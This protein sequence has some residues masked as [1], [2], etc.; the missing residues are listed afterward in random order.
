MET[1]S[2]I[3]ELL[4]Q[5]AHAYYILDNPIMS[6]SE[7]DKLY[8]QLVDIETNDPSLITPDS[9]TQRVGAALDGE[10]EEIKHYHPMLSLDNV[11]NEKDIKKF[12]KR[13][14]NE[15]GDKPQ[16]LCEMK[17][18]GAA[19]SLVYQD[20]VL[21]HGA[22]RGDGETGEDITHNVRT[23]NT[24]PLR[25]QLAVPGRVEVRGEVIMPHDGF[26]AYNAKAKEN[27]G[28][29]FANPRNAAAGSL[30]QKDPSKTAGRPLVFIPY[31]LLIE[32]K[33]HQMV[34]NH[35]QFS[36]LRD[37][38]FNVSLQRY[39]L[40]E[41][42]ELISVCNRIEEERDKVPFDIDGVVIKVNHISSQRR[43]G[44]LSRSPRWAT[45]Y[46]FKAQEKTTTL[47]EV[48][49]QVGRT[50]A[51]TPVARLEPVEVGGVMVSN[52]TL[53]NEDEITRLG[54]MIGD[55]VVVRR[56]GDVIPQITM[57]ELNK[58]PEDARPIHFPQYCPVCYSRVMK[59]RGLAVMRCIGGIAC[60]AQLKGGLSHFVSRLAFNID[61]IGDQLIEQLVDNKL[62][63][64]PEQLFL[65]TEE[66]LKTLPRMGDKSCQR[67]LD[68]IEAAKSV[69]FQRFIYSL[70][71]PEVG[72]GT[73]KRLANHFQHVTDLLMTTQGEL[74]S[75]VDIGPLTAESII[76]FFS[77]Q[78]NRD[79]IVKLVGLEENTPLI[80]IEYPA[81]K[82]NRL[83]GQSWVITGSF[84]IGSREDLKKMI[85]DQG[86]KVSG[87]V[88]KQTTH[89]LAGKGGG[90]KRKEAARLNVPVVNEAEF[91]A[92]IS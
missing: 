89:L 32:S 87:K 70:G 14:E 76:Q 55:S 29:V 3:R 51:I 65:L 59:P 83:E 25:L 88:T 15:L 74:E 75:I 10:F 72:E 81:P 23:L 18:D 90:S 30:R 79:T 27:G 56:A 34:F 39:Y 58:R 45:S 48:D 54:V 77:V 91:Q 67:I 43:L 80:K 13:I 71:I 37:L 31:Q 86:G 35:Q 64:S 38:G 20:G 9:P 92:M 62:V 19:V 33:N 7:Y 11:F 46:K 66:Q 4:N 22:T 42:D 16:Y 40:V 57:V 12:C 44:F 8:R 5:A 69:T 1:T 73:S 85:E 61:N 6:D 26:E 17:L 82:G 68:S 63:K 49:F 60:S 2:A 28:R 84:D 47:L 52:A 50:G 21:I 36:Y 53:H 78:R 41:G 24:V